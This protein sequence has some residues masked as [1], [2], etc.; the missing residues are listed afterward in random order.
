[1]IFGATEEKI[2]NKIYWR[3]IFIYIYVYGNCVNIFIVEWKMETVQ[4]LLFVSNVM[5]ILPYN[6]QLNRRSCCGRLGM[7]SFVKNDKIEKKTFFYQFLKSFFQH[8][9]HISL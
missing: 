2:F 1:M 6:F 5:F 7:V 8:S 4:I 3:H 9:K